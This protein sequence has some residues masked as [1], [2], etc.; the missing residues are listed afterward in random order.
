MLN[1]S[2]SGSGRYNLKNFVMLLMITSIIITGCSKSDLKQY[3]DEADTRIKNRIDEPY[4][5]KSS[6]VIDKAEKRYRYNYE[7]TDRELC[8]YVDTYLVNN[9]RV[10]Y[11][12]YYDLIASM[13]G[14][15]IINY[16]AEADIRFNVS[17]LQ[18]TVSS[19]DEAQKVADALEKCEQIY[20]VEN[21]WHKNSYTDEY[22]PVTIY[23]VNDAGEVFM[24]HDFADYYYVGVKPS[25][26]IY[27]ELIA[28]YAY[29]F[30]EDLQ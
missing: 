18:I 28:L 9:E 30:G 11:T 13:Y 19:L 29:T 6:A 26:A 17:I 22:S 3:K 1:I 23:L 12:N 2:S 21:Q 10:Y 7:T 16:L 15:E 27:E 5:Y 4:E 14:D 25:S 20:S 8:F 24:E